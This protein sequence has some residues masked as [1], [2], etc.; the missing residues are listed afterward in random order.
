MQTENHCRS[1]F[2]LRGLIVGL[3][4]LFVIAPSLRA[5][6]SAATVEFSPSAHYSALQTSSSVDSMLIAPVAVVSPEE[7]GVVLEDSDEMVRDD[8]RQDRVTAADYAA[9]KPGPFPKTD[10]T[11]GLTV[12]R[13]LL[14]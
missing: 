2:I 14:V 1:R 4:A 8:S 3:L 5:A 11:R 7:F 6:E 10:L 13:P 12:S 9:S